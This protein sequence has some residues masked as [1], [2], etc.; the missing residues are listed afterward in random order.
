MDAFIPN[1]DFED[2]TGDALGFTHVLASLVNRD[3]VGSREQR[4]GQ[5]EQQRQSECISQ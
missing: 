1:S 3:A 2:F 5:Q 4:S